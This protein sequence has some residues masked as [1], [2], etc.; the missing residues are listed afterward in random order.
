MVFWI[1]GKGFCGKTTTAQGLASVVPNA[2]I[3]D[4]RDMRRYFPEGYNDDGRRNNIMRL[5]KFAAILERRGFTPIVCCVSP[6]KALREEARALFNE[7]LLIY[8]PGGQLWE[9][10]TYEEPDSFEIKRL[11]DQVDDTANAEG[12]WKEHNE[13]TQQ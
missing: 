9:G 8:V 12:K 5:A 10:T 6:T 1:T 3:L 11:P 13:Q 4:A 2:V 7:S